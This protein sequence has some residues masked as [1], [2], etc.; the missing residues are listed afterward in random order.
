MVFYKQVLE[1]NCPSKFLFQTSGRQNHWSLLYSKCLLLLQAVQHKHFQAGHHA[2]PTHDPYWSHRYSSRLVQTTIYCTTWKNSR[3]EGFS[4]R[5]NWMVV[6]HGRGWILGNNLD[7][8]LKTFA[9][10]YSQSPPP[11]DFTP[12]MVFLNLRFLQHQLKVGGGLAL[13]TLFLC[14]SWKDALFF[15]SLHFIYHIYKYI[16]SQ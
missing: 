8:N 10:Y 5:E 1:F 2:P 9:P 11:A 3:V 7:K 6:E 15:L 16:F 14:F 13:F 4:C 12:P